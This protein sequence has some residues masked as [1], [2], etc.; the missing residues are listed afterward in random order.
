VAPFNTDDD[1]RAP[2]LNA[3]LG[4]A[5]LKDIDQIVNNSTVMRIDETLVWDVVAFQVYV[6]SM[7]VMYLTTDTPDIQFGFYAPINSGV[8]W[9]GTGFSGG[10]VHLNFANAG[11]TAPTTFGASDGITPR[12]ARIAAT[13]SMGD[14]D[15]EF[16]LAYAQNVATAV[17]TTVM[18]GSFGVLRQIT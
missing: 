15:G 18:A 12:V 5:K 9:H 2:A 7:S 13:L 8:A 3:A 17:D 4:V 1:L 16:G 11:T 14:T 10:S 6:L